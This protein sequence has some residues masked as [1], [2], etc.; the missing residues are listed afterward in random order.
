VATVHLANE[1]AKG[2]RRLPDLYV[3]A[4]AEALRFLAAE[5]LSGKPLR[6]DYLGSRSR[7][8]GAYRI[9]YAFDRKT[10]RVEIFA[11]RHR[12]EAYRRAR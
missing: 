1:A 8:V 3:N 5:P 12:S 2:L 11:I 9:V 7:R 6:G 10:G 4:V